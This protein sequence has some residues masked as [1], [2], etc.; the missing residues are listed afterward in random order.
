M[1][2]INKLAEPPAGWRGCALVADDEVVSR[3]V[4]ARLLQQEGFTVV[5][6]ADGAEAVAL[7]MAQ[8]PGFD[9]IFMDALMPNMDGFEATQQIKALTELPFVPVIFQSASQEE[10]A[11]VRGLEAGGDDFLTKPYNFALLRT[12]IAAMERVRDL[13]RSAAADMAPL[14]ALL[15]SERQEQHLAERIFSRAIKNRNVATDVI[16][17]LLRPA[18]TFSGD[19]VLTQHLPDGGL[20]VLLGDFTGHGLAAAIAALPVADAF[21]AMTRK[22]VDD[23][24]ILAELNRKL[25]QLLPVERF[26]AACL[27]SIPGN[28]QTLRWWNG[29]LPS[30]WLRQANGLHELTSF[31]LP[32]GILPELPEN[33][34]PRHVALQVD[35]RLLMFSDGLLEAQNCAGVA[36]QDAGFGAVLARWQ[37]ADKVFSAMIDA[38][39]QHCLHT[40][41][42]DDIAVVEVP[43]NSG[44]FTA[45]V[46]RYQTVA[47]GGWTWAIELHDHQLGALRSVEAMLRPLGVL[48]GLDA[49][50]V[51]LE[52]IVAEL[53]SNALE[54]GILQLSSALKSAPD[55][56]E[57]YYG[58]RAD[59]LNSGCKGW[60]HVEMRYTP[61]DNGGQINICFQDSGTGFNAAAWQTADPNEALAAARPWGRGIALVRQLCATLTYHEKGRMVEAVY[62]W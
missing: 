18:A 13:Q 38:L 43:L 52:T 21:H 30:A 33:A 42:A 6:A 4:L 48:D 24:E 54:H 14:A 15:D 41:Q 51:A 34:T 27:I 50:L 23:Q 36:F 16:G 46:P 58:R 2:N 22:G 55:G 62:R 45:P 10:A 26:M 5:Q 53:Y 25:Y 35:D 9:L 39:D 49:H 61:Q 28:R 7:F 11:L 12:R 31:A 32:L 44:L 20:R 29:G 40:E 1:V 59:S 19:L 17:L 56:F 57:L 8:Q 3:Q 47:S 37:H 60:I